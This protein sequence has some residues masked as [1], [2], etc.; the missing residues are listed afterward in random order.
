MITSVVWY[1]SA[2]QG[3]RGKR[4]KYNVQLGYFFIFLPSSGEH[5]LGERRRIFALDDLFRWGLIS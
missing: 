4:L 1:K 2:Q 3:W 5:I